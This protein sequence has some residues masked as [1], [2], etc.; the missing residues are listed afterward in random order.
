[1]K[2]LSALKGIES[3]QHQIFRCALAESSKVPDSQSWDERLKG[4]LQGAVEQR[5]EMRQM[6]ELLRSHAKVAQVFDP[7]FFQKLPLSSEWVSSDELL[8]HVKVFFELAERQALAVESSTNRTRDRDIGGSAKDAGKEKKKVRKKGKA[9]KVQ[10]TRAPRSHDE[11]PESDWSSSRSRT[12]S[13]RHARG[14]RRMCSPSADSRSW[15]S[16]SSSRSCSHGRGWPRRGRHR[17]GGGSA[18]DIPADIERFC[19]VN[20][21]EMRCEKILRDLSPDLACR[22]MGL[23]GGTNTFELSGDVR[24]PTAVVLARIRKARDGPGSGFQS[25]RPPRRP[26]SIS[27][28]RSRGRHACRPRRQPPHSSSVGRARKSASRRRDQGGSRPTSGGYPG[29]G[30]QQTGSNAVPLGKLREF[31]LKAQAS[32]TAEQ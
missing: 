10:R 12:H 27:S 24:D 11:S 32:K 5:E 3:A 16:R 25:R 8:S 31:P 1:M 20:R 15:S 4:I 18:G 14:R 23:S 6:L 13:R 17:I 28:S 22:V 2:G 7:S 26:R 21:L 19:R 9:A 29:R 30:M